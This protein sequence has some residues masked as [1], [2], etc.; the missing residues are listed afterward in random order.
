MTRTV[1]FPGL[2]LEFHLDRV[3]FQLFGLPIYW[4]GV[5]IACGFLL[6]VVFC[7]KMAP[8]FG[9]KP[10]DVIDL[11]FFAVPLAIIGA[12]LYYIVFYLDLYR[13]EDGGLDFLEMLDIR[14]G[15]LAIYGGVIAAVIT[16]LV[17]CRVKKINFFAVADLGAFGLLIGQCIGRWGNF[18]NVEAYGGPTDLPWR[19]GID[20]YVDGVWQYMEVHPTFLYESLWNLLG[21]LLL[22]SVVLR[23]RRKFDGEIMWGYFLWYGFGRGLIE[24]L[25]TDSLYFF[26]TPIR[27]SQVLG[28]ASALVAAGFLFYHLVL[29]RHKPEELYVNRMAAARK[30]APEA[31]QQAEED[32]GGERG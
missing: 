23:G 22:L 12:R 14:D 27:V 7:Y 5:I 6:A 21:F 17:V 8:R 11:L 26:H 29:R 20:A 19:M 30:A 15:G 28:F 32:H 4:Y 2:G 3:A 18:V 10:D 25:R 9:V 16:L 31:K 1:L 13:T 24:G